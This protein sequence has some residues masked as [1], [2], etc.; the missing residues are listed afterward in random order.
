MHRE[1]H[2]LR[3]ER[4]RTVKRMSNLFRLKPPYNAFVMVT[5]TTSCE[6]SNT[7][8]VDYPDGLR[9]VFR[10]NKYVGWYLPGGVQE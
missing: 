10:D 6:D 4:V 5:A 8:Y 1:A 9:L 2:L 7:M 3:S